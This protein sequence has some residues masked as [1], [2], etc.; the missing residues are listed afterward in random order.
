MGDVITRLKVDS[1]EYDSKIK[2]AA[3]G[4]QHYA[5]QCRKAGGTLQYVDD[6]AMA[7]ARSL[8]RMETSAKSVRA[9]MLEFSEAIATLTVQYRRM[10]DEEKNGAYGKALQQSLTQ[11]KARAGELKDAM[12]DINEEVRHLASDTSFTDGVQLM[13]RTI[14]SCAAAIT[15]WTGD[16]KEMSAVMKDLAKIGT[17][18]AA[19]ESLTKAFQKQNL[20]MLKN[21]YVLAAAGIAATAVAVSQLIKHAQDLT[22]VQR[23]LNEVQ[24]KGRDNSAQEVTRIQSLNSILHDNTRSLDER[25]N[26]LGQIQALVPAYHGALTTEGTLI[27]DNTDALSDYITNLRRAATAQAAFDRMVEAQQRKL[28]KQLELEK[29]QKGLQSAQDNLHAS[30]TTPVYGEGGGWSAVNNTIAVSRA[31]SKVSSIQQDIQAIDKEIAALQNLVTAEDLVTTSTQKRT[32]AVSDNNAKIE[33]QLGILGQLKQEQTDLN[34]ALNTAKTEEEIRNIVYQLARVQE[35]IDRIRNSS[36]AGLIPHQTDTSMLAPQDSGKITLPEGTGKVDVAK[37]GNDAAAAWSNA[38]A[39]VSNVGSA[40]QSI[41]DP[42][43]KVAGVIMQAVAQVALGFAQAAASP[44]TGAAGV[45]GWVAAATAG[46]ATMVSI[47]ATIKSVTKGY[48]YGGMVNGYMGKL[49]GSPYT[50]DNVVARLNMGEGVLT[51]QGIA[52]ASAM[53][54]GGAAPVAVSVTGRISGRDILLA[55]DADNRSRGGSRYAYSKPR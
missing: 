12:S 24:Q 6:E 7:F 47:I 53:M 15:A 2:R 23:T 17:T 46:L 30:T 37:M 40:L 48:E 49:P 18:V 39:A 32:T 5:D 11:L 3:E 14:G 31:E 26:A 10:S 45:F 1:T 51:R 13:T 41:E 19:V 25:K 44:A 20:V 8:G 43:A 38:A 27:N 52:N 55:A 21:P 4:L 28:E 22:N 9:K 42:A 33:Q 34:N 54:N 35:R 50:G 16:S 29:A 36:K